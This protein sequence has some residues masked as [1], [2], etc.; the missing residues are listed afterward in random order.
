M[1]NEEIIKNWGVPEILKEKK[2]E[3]IFDINDLNSAVNK[4]RVI[5]GLYCD[6]KGPQF[7]LDLL[8]GGSKFC[9]YN[10]ESNKIIFTMEFRIFNYNLFDKK[11]GKS[12]KLDCICIND[13][14][15]IG[16]KIAKYYLR[17]LIK[18]GI[19][20]NIKVFYLYPNPDAELFE[21]IGKEKTLT[22]EELVKFYINTFKELDF[23]H[24]YYYADEEEEEGDPVS[25]FVK[26]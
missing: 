1:I 5:E 21:G 23:N 26:S 4:T 6:D 25:L 3:F 8:V 16:K 12:I 18:F 7:F 14:E 19:Y 22:K 15:M 9:L 2:I 17:K 11:L 13:S 10:K 20:N 24:K